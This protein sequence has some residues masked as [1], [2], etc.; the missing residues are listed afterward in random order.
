M[1]DLGAIRAR[2]WAIIEQ[3]TYVTDEWGGSKLANWRWG[4]NVIV[5]GTDEAVDAIV[6]EDITV[7]LAEVERLQA[8]ELAEREE[9]RCAVKRG[10]TLLAEVGK[11][12]AELAAAKGAL[13]DAGLLEKGAV[14]AI[15]CNQPEFMRWLQDAA[16]RIRE[17]RGE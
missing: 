10:D 9:K 6:A 17:A 16:R 4:S 1:F 11:L 12:R 5:G 13:P 15:A 3:H 7:L 8:V 2:L 14:F